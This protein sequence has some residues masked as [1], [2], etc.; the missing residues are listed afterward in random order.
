MLSRYTIVRGAKASALPPGIRQDTRKHTR[1]V[2][3][4]TA[5]MVERLLADAQDDARW[6]AFATRYR[7]LLAERFAGER[8]RFDALAELARTDDVLLGCNCPT[9]KNPDVR[10]CHTTLALAFMKAK[11]P[12]LDVRTP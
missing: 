2:L 6:R 4:P 8:E 1:H 3:R 12:D 7:A 9:A 11:Y 5:E 10:H